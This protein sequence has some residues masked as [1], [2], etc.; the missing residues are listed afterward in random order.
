MRAYRAVCVC[1][2]VRECHT[3]IYLVYYR[4]LY[5]AVGNTGRQSARLKLAVRGHLSVSD[6]GGNGSAG[7]VEMEGTGRKEMRGRDEAGGE[8][9]SITLLV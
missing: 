1:V 5:I 6:K 3:L 8:R 4:H 7:W 2:S 9:A